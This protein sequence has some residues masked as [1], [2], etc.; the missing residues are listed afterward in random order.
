MAFSSSPLLIYTGSLEIF[1]N[2]FEKIQKFCEN[3]FD[4]PVYST[5]INI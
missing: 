2:Y 1:K 4:E 5:I 3:L